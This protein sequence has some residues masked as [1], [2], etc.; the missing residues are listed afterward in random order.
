M[1]RTVRFHVAAERE[2]EEAFVWYE[3]ERP[4]LGGDFVRATRRRVADALSGPR[5]AR[6]ISV[7]GEPVLRVFVPRFPYVVFLAEI[8]E[9]IL[10]VAVLHERREP[11]YW[12]H[13]T[14]P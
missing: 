5:I 4:G 6:R 8:G 11:G 14:K 9:E 3:R 7:E 12:T 13:R 1:S 2:M 10:V